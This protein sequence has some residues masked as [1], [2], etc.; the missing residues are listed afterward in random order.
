MRII[1]R[2]L[3]CLFI[4]T[5]LVVPYKASALGLEV[6][7]GYWGQ[8]PSGS[9]ANN[10]VSIGTPAD[11]KSD[12][13][14]DTKYQPFARVKAELPVLLPNIYLMATPMS[15]DGTGA[16]NITYGGTTFTTGFNS[17]LKLDQYDVALYYS[18]PF[19]NTAT[20]GVLNAELGINAKIINFEGTLTQGSTAVSK[21]MTLYVPT[22]YAGVQVKPVKAFSIEAEGRGIAYGSNHYYDLIGRVKVM[23]FGPLFVSGGYRYQDISIDTS[24]IVATIK[25]SG[26]FVEAGLSF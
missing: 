10:D 13:K 17:K 15:Y 14:Y 18:L 2:Y 4:L 16:K 9:V 1:Q 20:V 25:F 6:A 19:L 12:L 5:M 3:T 24:G 21:S 11:L 22:I 8:S 7:V 26:P 23:A